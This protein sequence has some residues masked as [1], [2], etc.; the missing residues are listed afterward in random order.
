MLVVDLD[1]WIRDKAAEVLS[2]AE[3]NSL[4]LS[5]AADA[6]LK[7]ARIETKIRVIDMCYDISFNK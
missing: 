5:D 1:R 7:N 6:I 2:F 4:K 3:T